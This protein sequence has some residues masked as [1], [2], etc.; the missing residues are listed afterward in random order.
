MKLAL[1]TAVYPAAEPFL[2]EFQRS[3][4]GQDESDVPLYVMDDG[5]GGIATRFAR[6]GSRL[7]AVEAQGT[8]G[9][10]RSQGIRRLAADG[11]DAVVFADCDDQ[12]SANRVSVCRRLLADHA[13]VVNEL[14]AFGAG[15]AGPVPMLAPLMQDGALIRDGDLLHGNRIGLGN[16]A[17]RI[18]TLL[19]HL[20]RID[21]GLIAYDWALYTRVLHAGATARYTAQATTLYRQ[22]AGSCAGY[23]VADARTVQ[24]SVRVKASHYRDL[25]RLGSPYREL[26]TRFEALRDQLDRD[27][28]SLARYTALCAGTAHAPGAW[29]SVAILPTGDRV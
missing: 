5:L 20:D 7:K 25:D 22:H 24:H 10:I 19:P 14:V 17:A 2:D 27:P 13:V 23:Q 6:F 4:E 18:A 21:P 15:M 9:A 3:L 26:A 12:C 16:S 8:P 11:V 29:W 28:A 1:L